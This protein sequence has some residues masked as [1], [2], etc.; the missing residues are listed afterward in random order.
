VTHDPKAVEVLA[1]CRWPCSAI[2]PLV[3]LTAADLSIV[4]EGYGRIGG[5]VVRLEVHRCEP[6]E[7]WGYSHRGI[8]YGLNDEVLE[9]TPLYVAIRED[10]GAQGVAEGA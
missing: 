3:A 10:E 8:F 9:P 5:R 6:L 2:H 7:E 4:R 1:G